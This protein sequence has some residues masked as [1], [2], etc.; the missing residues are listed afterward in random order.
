MQSSKKIAK[1][2]TPLWCRRWRRRPG[3]PGKTSSLSRWGQIKRER[4]FCLELL[5]Y[6]VPFQDDETS[7]IIL[8]H[9]IRRE[10]RDDSGN[11]MGIIII[12]KGTGNHCIIIFSEFLRILVVTEEHRTAT[13]LIFREGLL[14]RPLKLARDTS[15]NI[16]PLF[17][18]PS[19]RLMQPQPR[20]PSKDWTEI[21]Q[22]PTNWH[23][24][25]NRQGHPFPI[26]SWS[27][28]K[29]SLIAIT[30]IIIII[31]CKK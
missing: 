23:H 21:S 4:T 20:C 31:Q 27:G 29:L 1:L 3:K 10:L 12:L 15:S 9:P 18:V 16:G 11:T 30:N 7:T 13:I 14:V 17:Y 25:L 5:L 2:N 28:Y 6:R 19:E 8:T 26:V 24:E 22:L